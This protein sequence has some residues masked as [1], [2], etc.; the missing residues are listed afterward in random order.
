MTCFIETIIMFVEK[1]R[2]LRKAA[3]LWAVWLITWTVMTSL[4]LTEINGAVAT[5]NTAV[6]GILSVVIKFL[7]DG[8]KE[9][10]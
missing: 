1:H 2:L 8:D 3:L 4:N 9:G 7:V 6:I 5:I 10:D